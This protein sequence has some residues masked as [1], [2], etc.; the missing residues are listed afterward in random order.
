VDVAACA[1][2]S[3][4]YHVVVRID[5]EQASSWSVDEVLTLWAQLFAGHQTVQRYLANPAMDAAVLDLLVPSLTAKFSCVRR[6]PLRGMRRNFLPKPF[7]KF[8]L[9][10]EQFVAS[11]QVHPKLRFHT[12]VPAKTQCCIRSD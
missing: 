5:A 9:C 7:V 6:H 3:N 8:F 2:M 10:A 4:H 1:V 11:L 12:E